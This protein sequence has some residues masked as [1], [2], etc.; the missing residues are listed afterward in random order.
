LLFSERFCSEPALLYIPKLQL[1]DKGVEA[2]QIPRFATRLKGRLG[3]LNR[4]Y[5]PYQKTEVLFVPDITDQYPG[6]SVSVPPGFRAL[7][8]RAYGQLYH[9]RDYALVYGHLTN[10]NVY[11]YPSAERRYKALL[12]CKSEA[13]L[14]AEI[15]AM[16][17]FAIRTFDEAEKQKNVRR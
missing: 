14:D 3:M 13:Q 10:T 8:S 5:C 16:D 6:A 15:N 1:E 4:R 17:H 9:L 12:L 11:D 7:L 2:P